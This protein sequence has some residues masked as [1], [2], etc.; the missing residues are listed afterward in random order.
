MK[1][2]SLALFAA[3]A[4][5][6]VS[7]GSASAMPFANPASAQESLIQD[8]RVVC[9]RFGRCYNTNRHYGHRYGHRYGYRGYGGNAPT[10][11]IAGQA[12]ASASASASASDRLARSELAFGPGKVQIFLKD[13]TY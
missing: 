7:I 9:D 12:L 10:A 11:I 2:F 5:G 4:I 8:V 6:A 13:S 1:A 3:S